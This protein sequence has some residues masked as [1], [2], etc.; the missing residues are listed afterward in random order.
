MC[1]TVYLCALLYICVYYCIFMCMTST[2]LADMRNTDKQQRRTSRPH[3]ITSD[4]TDK[5]MTE[6]HTRPN[7]TH[8]T[9]DPTP[10]KMHAECTQNADCSQNAHFPQHARTYAGGFSHAREIAFKTA[11]FFL[12]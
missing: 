10:A 3:R 8:D 7:E 9:A 12:F 2:S 4:S 1:T 11:I 5:A 6:R